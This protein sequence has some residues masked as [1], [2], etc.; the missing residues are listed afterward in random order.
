[1]AKLARKDS[2]HSQPGFIKFIFRRRVGGLG[3]R[4]PR[5]AMLADIPAQPGNYTFPSEGLKNRGLSGSAQWQC[6]RNGSEEIQLFNHAFGPNHS[7]YTA[8]HYVKISVM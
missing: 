2:G 6:I 5:W 1:M 7:G 3:A 4:P 8:K